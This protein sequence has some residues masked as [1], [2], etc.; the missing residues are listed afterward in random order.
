M[1]K[2]AYV[3]L[4]AADA[5]SV[6]TMVQFYTAALGW[7]FEDWGPTYQA[8]QAGVDGGLNGEP[9]HRTVAPLVLLQTD[10]LESAEQAVRAAGG[11]AT[12]PIFTYPGGRRFHFRDPAGN[13]LGMMQVETQAS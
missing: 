4:P 8:F 3:E 11:I 10:D 5:E 9:Q 7:T 6:A 13:E 1:N 2:I 12:L